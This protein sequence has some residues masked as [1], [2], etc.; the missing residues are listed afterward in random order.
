MALGLRGPDDRE[1]YRIDLVDL[2]A[3]LR[4]LDL[5]ERE[6]LL[7]ATRRHYRRHYEAQLGQGPVY[8]ADALFD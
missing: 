6:A 1:R 4:A 3:R 5:A 8:P 7:W 2:V